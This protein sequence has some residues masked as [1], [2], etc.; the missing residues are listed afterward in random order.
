MIISEYNHIEG[1]T[2]EL[3]EVFK[4]LADENRVRILN[5]LMQEELCVCEIETILNISQSN[6]SKHLNKLKNSGIITSE[7]KAQ[8][9]YYQISGKF[10]DENSQLYE[11]LKTKVD[12]N[13]QWL[14]DVE[15]LKKYKNSSFTCEQLR[16]YKSQ[17]LNILKHNVRG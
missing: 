15:R 17:V 1:E 12:K 10:K 14:N 16:E 11:F 7:K 3:I 5:L 9:V 2:M 8:W 6:A 13:P 4:A